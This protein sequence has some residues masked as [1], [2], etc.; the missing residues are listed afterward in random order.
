MI[1]LKIFS[2]NGLKTLTMNAK[3]DVIYRI[4]RTKFWENERES[5]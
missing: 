3:P 4:Q 2:F 1:L 5:E